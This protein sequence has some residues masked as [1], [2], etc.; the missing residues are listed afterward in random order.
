MVEDNAAEQANASLENTETAEGTQE[1]QEGAEHSEEHVETEQQAT[2]QKDE[3]ADNAEASRIGR[4]VKKQLERELS[5]L[6]AQLEEANATIARLTPKEQKEAN[7]PPPPIEGFPTTPE[8]FVKMNEWAETVRNTKTRQQ[9]SAYEKSYIASITSLREEGGDLH[10]QIQELLTKDGSP[11][12]KTQGTGR[13]DIDAMLNYRI[14]HRDILANKVKTKGPTF[15][16]KAPDG[17]ATGLSASS[18]TPDPKVAHV[19]FD[20]PRAE[21]FAQYLGYT[22]EERAKIVSTRK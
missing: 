9:V 13:G 6:K 21:E 19:K 16:K 4:I 1:T 15:G 8:E 22:D 12:N 3:P 18:R 10:A 11:Y 2:P 14:A 20:D 5:P 17:V 7:L